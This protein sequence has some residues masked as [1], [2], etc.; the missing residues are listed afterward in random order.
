MV[1]LK[2]KTIGLRS[3][4]IATILVSALGFG[5]YAFLS[6]DQDDA[7]AY[8]ARCVTQACREAADAAVAAEAA[9]ATAAS[10][11][12]T[13]EG[14]IARL[15]AEISAL[16]AEIAAN[17]AVANDLAE[18][19]RINEEKLNLQQTALAKLLVNMHFE[20][21]PDAI[22][23]LASSS[24]LG[25]YAERQ[26]RQN[27]AKTQ[28]AASAEAVRELKTELEK[29][30]T[31]VDDLIASSE[32]M[33][34]EATAKRNQQYALKV[35]YENDSEAYTRDA[36]A[37]REKMQEEIRAEMRRTQGNGTVGSGY[38]SYPYAGNCPQDDSMYIVLGGYV[39]QC[40]SYTAWKVKEFWGISIYNWGNAADWGR[41]AAAN[42]YVVDN[43]PTPFS[44]GYSESGY[45]GH[46]VWVES[47]N[48]DGTINLTEYNNAYSSA[49]GSWGDFGARNHVPA[50]G[51][52]YIHF[53]EFTR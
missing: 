26:S 44:V 53:D 52:R 34:S 23:L 3:A 47:V 18:Q 8:D 38:N 2:H 5:A 20:E 28:V 16:E 42:G 35:K 36:I 30:K 21:E 45:Y 29:Q 51:F 13:L 14:E 6:H 19:I 41:Y 22:L 10:N 7:K 49:S 15:N 1:S 50:S 40:V 27:T 48:G 25:D 46:V 9:A 11:A 33:A 37:A 12:Q 17:Q 39:C 24:S 43:N 4:I 31:V 32:F